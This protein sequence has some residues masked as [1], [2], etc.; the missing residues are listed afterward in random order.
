MDRE[1]LPQVGKRI[2]RERED[3]GY[4]REKFAELAGISPQFLAEIENGKKGMSSTTLYKIC[5]RFDISADYL[6]L[7]RL[8]SAN[9]PATVNDQLRALPEPYLS[10][11]EEIIRAIEQVARNDNRHQS[12]PEQC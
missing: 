9:L 1:I 5:T 2:R 11:T 3:R 4:T 6:L 10:L 8:A 7:G 12:E